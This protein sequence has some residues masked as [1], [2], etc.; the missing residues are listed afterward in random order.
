MVLNPSGVWEILS[1]SWGSSSFW[2]CGRAMEGAGISVKY[3]KVWFGGGLRDVQC[4]T[5][6]NKPKILS[7]I[8]SGV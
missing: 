6:L 4:F 1:C 3:P 5:A 7:K 8:K 2:R